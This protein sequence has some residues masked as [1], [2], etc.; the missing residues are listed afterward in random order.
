MFYQVD[1]NCIVWHH[2]HIPYWTSSSD[3]KR[4]SHPSPSTLCPSPPCQLF[5]PPLIH[6]VFVCGLHVA[7]AAWSVWVL[8]CMETRWGTQRQRERGKKELV[9]ATGLLRALW[10][11]QMSL[12]EAV[13]WDIQGVEPEICLEA[14][15]NISTMTTREFSH[16]KENLSH[17]KISTNNIKHHVRSAPVIT[18]GSMPTHAEEQFEVKVQIL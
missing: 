18:A 5:Q 6:S 16:K 8:Q 10:I 2:E 13:T 15:L 1:T 3:S 4:S 7:C 12:E 14:T 17:P 11:H 9:P